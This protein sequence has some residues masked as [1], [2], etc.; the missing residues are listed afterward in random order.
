[1]ISKA[2]SKSFTNQ[3]IVKSRSG[4]H[5]KIARRFQKRFSAR[6]LRDLTRLSKNFLESPKMLLI[7]HLIF[8]LKKTSSGWGQV[9]QSFPKLGTTLTAFSITE[10][11]AEGM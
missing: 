2:S 9:L 11:D 3:N 4:H 8:L 5:E 1:M 7:V 6:Q 10:S